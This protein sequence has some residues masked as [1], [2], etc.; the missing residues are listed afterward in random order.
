MVGSGNNISI[1]IIRRDNAQEKAKSAVYPAIAAGLSH[2]SNMPRL[3][4]QKTL[5]RARSLETEANPA[6]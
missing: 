3:H 6:R 2:C 1:V 4:L 5:A